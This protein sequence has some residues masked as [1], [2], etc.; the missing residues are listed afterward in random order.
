[1]VGVRTAYDKNVSSYAYY[2]RDLIEAEVE[3]GHYLNAETH[4]QFALSGTQLQYPDLY[5][6][7]LSDMNKRSHYYDYRQIKAASSVNHTFTERFSSEFGLEVY[8]RDY[9]QD[10]HDSDYVGFVEVPQDTYLTPRFGG[11]YDTTYVNKDRPIYAPNIRQKDLALQM[12][13]TTT[14]A[15]FAC[16]NLRPGLTIRFLESNDDYYSGLFYSPILRLECPISPARISLFYQYEAEIFPERS[17]DQGTE[18]AHAA[19]LETQY[20]FSNGLLFKMGYFLKDYHTPYPEENY[21]KR[22]VTASLLYSL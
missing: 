3:A 11:G 7:S 20:R 6:L 4:L 14:V 10:T 8:Y 5:R 9:F 17:P 1:M 16:L 19:G 18:Q 2:Q 21:R 12:N 13:L 15:I 22:L